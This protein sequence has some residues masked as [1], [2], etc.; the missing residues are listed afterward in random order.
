MSKIDK[1]REEVHRVAYQMGCVTKDQADK[2][3]SCYEAV[4]TEQPECECDEI[5]NGETCVKC[6]PSSDQPVAVSL[7][8]CARAII[9]IEPT[10]VFIFHPR[11]PI[12]YAKAVLDA[13]GVSY[14]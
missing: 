2:I 1:A 14:E 7:D 6:G 9:D 5:S 12:I 13:A 4:I 3:I 10:K 8:V 11:D